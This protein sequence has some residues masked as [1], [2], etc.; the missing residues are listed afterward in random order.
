LG[1]PWGRSLADIDAELKTAWINY[2]VAKKEASKLRAAHNDRL[3][4]AMATKQGVTAL[5]LQNNLNQIE[6]LQKQ[7]QRVRWALDKLKARGLTQVE[8]V[9]GDQVLKYTS[10]TDIEKACGEENE[11]R[12]R[13]AYGRPVE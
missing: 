2:R 7:A 6:R 3:Y 10:K 11:Q 5:Q 13:G 12:F 9:L 1:N 4:E 8:V